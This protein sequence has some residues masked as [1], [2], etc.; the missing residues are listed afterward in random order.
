MRLTTVGTG[1]IAMSPARVRAGHLV[2]AGAVRLLMDCGS[3]VAHRMA[4]RGLDWW[5]LT[6][7]ALT[8]FH[9]DH[10]ADLPT[11]LF[12]WKYGRRPGREAPLEVIGPPGTLSLV[13]RL[14]AAFGEWVAAPGFPLSVRELPPG[15]GLDLGDGVRIEAR[16]VPHTDESVAY[17]V[18]RGA[19]RV[20][21]TGDT[22]WDEGLGGWAAGADVLLAECSLPAAMAIPIH[23]TPEEC[24]RLAAA[25]R[26]RVLA[27]THL[28]PPVEAVDI[29]AAVAAQGFAGTVAVAEDGWSINVEEG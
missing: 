3:G 26:P 15:E 6:H 22:G 9:A 18:V 20:V 17:S 1:T 13:A 19:G 10:V 25:A 24:G 23:L 4:E 14:A 21:Y 11:L 5:G 12:A 8:H 27:L 7:V 16:K 2:E 29:R 28:Y